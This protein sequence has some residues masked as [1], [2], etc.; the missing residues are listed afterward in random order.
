MKKLLLLVG[1][2][3]VASSAFAAEIKTEAS[4]KVEIFAQ[5]LTDLNIE[6][7]PLNFG[8]L[9][10]DDNKTVNPSQ[11]EA[12][13]FIIKGASNTNISLTIEDTIDAN[14]KFK[15]G[16]ITAKLLREGGSNGDAYNDRLI[17]VIKIFD[18]GNQ[19]NDSALS[20]NIAA[21]GNLHEVK[22]K[23]FKVAGDIATRPEQNTGSYKGA[24]KVTAK[25]DSWPAVTPAK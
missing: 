22:S 5:V 2:L 7:E 14:N 10:L 18:N 24:I 8:I 19:L 4:G 1:L 9:G 23:E 20:F 17:P 6:T 21:T 16:Q 15:N 11:T 25:Y 13:K 3:V 12:G